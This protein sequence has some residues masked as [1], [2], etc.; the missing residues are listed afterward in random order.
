MILPPPSLLLGRTLLTITTVLV[1]CTVPAR[2]FFTSFQY[3]E[4]SDEEE[5]STGG[6]AAVA[7]GISSTTSTSS[8][9]LSLL[10]Q[11]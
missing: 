10:L 6:V 4:V 7:V 8:Y 11:P 3:D 1:Q 5:A 9:I 2:M